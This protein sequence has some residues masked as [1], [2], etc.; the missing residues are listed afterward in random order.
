MT[1]DQLRVFLSVA[2]RGHVTRASQVLNLSQS[3]V[4]ASIAALQNQHGVRLFDRVGRSIELTEAGRL[5]VNEARSV[6]AR[7]EAATLVL[8][9]LAKETRGRLRIRASQTVAS[10]WLPAKLIELHDSNPGIEL[11]FEVANT[12]QVEKA[13]RD[14]AADIG[15][16]EG[17][18]DQQELNRRVVA[19]DV[20]VMVM[21]PD[22]PLAQ[23][24]EIK[25]SD[26]PGLEW[27]LREPGSGTRSEFIRH[28]EKAGYAPAHLNIAMELPS[29]EAVLAA[30]ASGNKVSVLSR[31]AATDAYLCGRI[32]LFPLR[33]ATRVFSVLTH[34]GRHHTRAMM[35]MLDLLTKAPPSQSDA[36]NRHPVMKRTET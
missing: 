20:L 13:V 31:R 7:A 34:P 26:Y 11:G 25:P 35:A 6:L 18:I 10:Y 15:F 28:L 17:E 8:E 21:A 23:R 32:K 9:D 16:V 2:E 33:G 30:I 4:S 1:L 36:H 12:A 14:G 19:E 5:F 29:N 27:I 24:K 3:A 22:H